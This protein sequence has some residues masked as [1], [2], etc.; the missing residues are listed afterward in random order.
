ME[1][2]EHKH[3]PQGQCS[4]VLWVLQ[5]IVSALVMS[6]WMWIFLPVFLLAHCI[7]GGWLLAV[8]FPGNLG[9]LRSSIMLASPQREQT[10]SIRRMLAKCDVRVARKIREIL[11]CDFHVPDFKITQ[12]EMDIEYLP[13]THLHP[14]LRNCQWPS[15]LFCV[16]KHLTVA[17]SFI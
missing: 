17:C 14:S 9:T 7:S 11:I 12:K 6:Y 15:G 3:P 1:D 10:Q 4:H 13:H 2:T 5:L 16:R 8:M